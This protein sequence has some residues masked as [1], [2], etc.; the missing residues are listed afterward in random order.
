MRNIT[1]SDAKTEFMKKT[2][3]SAKLWKQSAKLM[4]GGITANIKYYE[5]HP[6]FMKKAKG[7]R[8][9][10]VD[11]NEYVDYCLC[12][13]P[14]ILGHGHPAVI[15]A[16]KKQLATSGTTMYGTPHELEI[17]MASEFKSPDSLRGDDKVRKLRPRSNHARSQNSSSLHAQDQNRKV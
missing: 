15:E 2:P 10:D 6:V 7:S 5:P 14:L 1:L 16:I 12:L 13:G 4:P 9:I 11:N 8:I 3:T 17:Q